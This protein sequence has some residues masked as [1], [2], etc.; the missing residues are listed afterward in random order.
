MPLTV[1][2][3]LV[4]IFWRFLFLWKYFA[5]SFLLT[6]NI[7]FKHKISTFIIVYWV[8]ADTVLDYIF[9]KTNIIKNISFFS[10]L[11]VKFNLYLIPTFI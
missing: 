8:C 10:F 3:R 4:E 5:D 1:N 7:T 2:M 6:V 9:T 11:A